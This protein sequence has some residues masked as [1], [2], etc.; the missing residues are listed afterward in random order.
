[1]A[2]NDFLV[3]GLPGSEKTEIRKIQ[4][5]S[6][7]TITL[8]ANLSNSH[9]EN[10]N[11]AIIEYDQIEL[12][13]ST[14][15][16]GTYALV[17]GT[18]V[19]LAIDEEYTELEDTGAISSDYFKIRYY[20]THSASYSGYSDSISF[21]GF[22]RYALSSII[23]HALQLADDLKEKIVTRRM[24]T[25][26]IN[27]WK[28]YV[29]SEIAESNEKYF[30]AYYALPVSSGDQ[31]VEFPASLR[32]RKIQ[33][34]EVN[35]NG[36]SFIRATWEDIEDDDPIFNY[37]ANN[38]RYYI[39]DTKLGFRPS[40]TADCTAKVWYVAQPDDLENDGDLL[41]DPVKYYLANLYD[42]LQ[43]KIYGQK[44]KHSVSKQYW[45]QFEFGLDKII[46]EINSRVLDE[47]R[48]IKDNKDL[49]FTEN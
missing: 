27:Q 23:D 38:P 13:K 42:F 31:E 24:I 16:N 37:N 36:G 5:I 29:C 17:S 41:S 19:N 12:Y 35:L 43:S 4:S 45:N 47:N 7:N 6:G 21:G 40:A 49:F 30:L 33:K 2:A 34:I 32:M 46:E 44:R 48:E 8:T 1:M 39:N 20:N 25:E 26:W 18:L 28:D 22:D 15:E 9:G 10:T 3:I 11:I 14:T